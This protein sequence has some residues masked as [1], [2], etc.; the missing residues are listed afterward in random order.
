[1]ETILIFY[2]FLDDFHEILKA[3]KGLGRGRTRGLDPVCSV[4]SGPIHHLKHW[5]SLGLIQNIDL[6]LKNWYFRA[7]YL[8]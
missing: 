4:R 1:M 2:S 8:L 5:L 3:K 7:I 6:N